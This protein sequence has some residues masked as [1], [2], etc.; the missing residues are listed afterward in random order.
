[1]NLQELSCLFLDQ[2]EVEL[3]SNEQQVET[4]KTKEWI[5]NVVCE[6]VESSHIR[7]M[8]NLHTRPS[9]CMQVVVVLICGVDDILLQETVV[10]CNKDQGA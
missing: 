9:H 5:D 4:C 8:L 1:M 10:Y 2:C 6:Q 7:G 3:L